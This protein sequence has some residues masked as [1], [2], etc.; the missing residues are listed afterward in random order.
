MLRR[1]F[2]AP[3]VAAGFLLTLVAV[4]VSAG[5]I[6]AGLVNGVNFCASDNN[7]GCT[8][9]LVLLDTDPTVGSLSLATT[10]LGG[11]T[12][13]G[14]LHTQVIG[15]PQNILNSSSLSITNNTAGT[16]AAQLAVGGVDFVGP[17]QAIDVSGSGTWQNATGSTATLSWYADQANGH[18]ADTPTDFPGTL[19]ASLSDVAGIGVDSFSTN[20]GLIVP[21]ADPNLFSMTLGYSMNLTAGGSLISRGQNELAAVAPVPEPA[22]MLLLGT[23][24]LAAFRARRKKVN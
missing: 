20:G 3:F 18:G 6:L 23:G 7:V 8:N 14:S 5:P 15:P 4:P 24:L 12:V 11:V 10:T 2:F 22:S 1:Q 16:I 21:F 17:V 13:Q 19:L 9:G